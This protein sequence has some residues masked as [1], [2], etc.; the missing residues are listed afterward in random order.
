MD[1]FIISFLKGELEPQD[2][3]ILDYLK[4]D[5]LLIE[6]DR[7]EEYLKENLTGEVKTRFLAYVEACKTNML[8]EDDEAFCAGF[9]LGAKCIIDVFK[10]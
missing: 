4:K 2:R 7:N 8:M 5:K 10:E 6:L 1:G 3:P 9:R